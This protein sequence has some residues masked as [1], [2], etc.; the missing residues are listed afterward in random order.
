[1]D[2][3]LFRRRSIAIDFR[4]YN[5]DSGEFLGRI[6][7]IS[8]GGLLVYGSQPLGEEKKLRVRIDYPDSAGQTCSASFDAQ[9]QWS[10]VDVNPSL[11]ATG[12]RL[13]NLEQPDAAEALAALLDR[14]TV[15]PNPE[16]GD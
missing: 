4:I 3:R 9:I 6:G 15:G 13:V 1:M 16:T 2:H 7:D 10:K 14:F 11:H 5:A 12:L 8:P